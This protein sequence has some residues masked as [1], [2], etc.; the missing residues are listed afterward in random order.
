MSIELQCVAWTL[1]L[2]LVQILVP[3]TAKLFKFGLK[4]AMGPRDESPGPSSKL[5]MRLDRAQANLFETMPVFI[6]T[7]LVATLAA[8]SSEVTHQGA[9]LYLAARVVYVPLY[10]AGIPALRTLAWTASMVGIVMCLTP[11]LHA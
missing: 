11:L 5:I 7:V 10:I 8:R 3:T 1:V 4:W 2:A 9:M 6:A